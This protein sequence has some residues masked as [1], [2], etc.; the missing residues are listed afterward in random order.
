MVVSSVSVPIDKSLVYL[1]CV[2]EQSSIG[3]QCRKKARNPTLSFPLESR[4]AWLQKEAML[5]PFSMHHLTS[6]AGC[7]GGCS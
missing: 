5:A 1:V 6:E 7:I 2:L 3:Q 4:K